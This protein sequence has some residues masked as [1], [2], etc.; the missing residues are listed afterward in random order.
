ML[1]QMRRQGASIFVYLIFC[2]L[3]AIF[4][5]NFRPGQSRSDD[6]GCSG[7]SNPIISIDGN[8]VTQTAYHIAYSNPYN[9]GQQKQR[10]WVALE[11]LIRRELLAQEGDR[12]G[13]LVGDDLIDDQ[14]KKGYFFLGGQRANI[15]GAIETID[16]EKFYNHKAVKNWANQLNVSFNSYREEQK[17]A[18]LASMVADTL[19]SAVQVTRDEAETDYDYDHTLATYDVVSFKPD[20][21][22]SAMKVSDADIERYLAAHADA[23]QARYKADERTYKAVKRQLK[24]REIFI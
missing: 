14:I 23:V 11:T 17:R 2:L 4:I 12:R 8:E 22:K 21:Y 5:I 3:I 10:V 15:P 13:L 20:E 1:E 19:Q 24:L 9:Q 6:N 7:R 16:G 18:L